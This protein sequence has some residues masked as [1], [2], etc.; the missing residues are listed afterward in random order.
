MYLKELTLHGFKTFAKKT[1]LEFMAPTAD[2]CGI[3]A[4]VGPN[5]SGKSNVADALRWVLGEQRIKT[6]RGKAA[7][8]VIFSG[9]DGKTRSGFAEVSVTFGD[10][11]GIEGIEFSEVTITRRL[12][13]DG[14]SQYHI[15]NQSARLA[16]I[17]MLLAQAN[18][19]QKSYAIINQGQIDHVLV[20]SPEER[21][22]FFDDAT[23]V[24]PLQL[25]R[26][27]AALKI[28]RTRDNLNQ[29]E[30]LVEEIA[31][32]LRT[33]K[34]LITRL[35]QREEVES[36]L[37]LKQV[38][39]YGTLWNTVQEQLKTELSA[40][41]RID[42]SV[43]K[44]VGI[45]D[46]EREAF[47]KIEEAAKADDKAKDEVASAAISELQNRYEALQE[48][49]TQIQEERF[50]IQK[51]I[52]LAKVRAVSSWTPLP[53]SKIIEGI[54]NLKTTLSELKKKL[55]SDQLEAVDL[56]NAF[57][58]SEMLLNRLQKP[59]PEEKETDPE[60]LKKI[61]ELRNDDAKVVTELTI[62][63]QSMQTSAKESKQERT[64]LF[65]LQRRMMAAQEELH[66]LESQLNGRRVALARLETRSED[67]ERDMKEVF[68][69][70]DSEARSFKDSADTDKL[71]P[72][73]QQLRHRLDLIGGIDEETVKEFEEANTRHEFLENQIADLVQALNDTEKIIQELD[74]QITAQSS[75]LFK[76]I[77]Q[78]FEHYFKIL[79]RGGKAGLVEIKAKDVAPENLP[80][81]TVT[82]DAGEPVVI[83]EE[84]EKPKMTKREAERIVG[85][86]IFATPPG[87]KLKNINLLSGGE[88][89]LTSIALISAVMAT[90]PSPFVVLDEVDA[91]LDEANTVRFAEIVSELCGKT[92]FVVI[93]H[94]RATMHTADALYGVTMNNDGI[95]Q[96]LSVKLEDVTSESSARR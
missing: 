18:V 20:A 31:P 9:S 10:V 14:E 53:L 34:R 41:D 15:N 64:E 89:A 92:Q 96:L 55:A 47:K 81:P 65:A 27:S 91:A 28:N 42:I 50:Q 40:F 46:S 24:K 36:Q 3:T 49:R 86:D 30:L 56:D 12:Y 38:Q 22:G 32:R 48:K 61:D 59:A 8:D 13:R 39:Y 51:G 60:L 43:K 93:T 21:K 6:L 76:D 69:G 88:R 80:A 73:I 62:V 66:D 77:Q 17:H 58:S 52:E 35:S 75:R 85:V 82:D 72:E 44:Q 54:A 23:G 25:K 37:K 68:S 90:N 4:I 2:S 16:D 70:N 78:H 26:H 63:K 79:F 11:S 71:Y 94:N 7:S 19:G 45:L 29:A 33:L 1:T 87:K 95:S 84:D 83:D 74:D 67:L 5:G 57:K